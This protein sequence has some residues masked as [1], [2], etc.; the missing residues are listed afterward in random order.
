[1]GPVRL[2]KIALVAGAGLLFLL[3]GIN[4]LID[5]ETN[6]DVVKHILSMDM[7][8]PGPFAGRVI[9]AS[10]LHHIFYLGIIGLELAGGA[11]TMIGVLRLWRARNMAANDFNREKSFAI[12]GLAAVF[13]L[14]FIG[15][16]TIG[17]EWFQMWRAGDYNM[18]EPAFRFIGSIG[19]VMV[20][21]NQPDGDI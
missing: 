3:V 7:I 13:G 15:F 11:A 6:F 8:P 1:M 14:Y 18:Q 20:F 19:L 9:A 21:L 10:S 16:A 17:G 12:C 2:A 4:N 5:Y